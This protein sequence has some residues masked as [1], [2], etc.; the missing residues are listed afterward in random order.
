VIYSGASK[1]PS[2]EEGDML[3]VEKAINPDEMM[4]TLQSNNRNI[5][6]ITND[7]KAISKGILEGKG[8]VGKL[9]SDETLLDDF[10][11]T[12]V[13]L[14]KASSNAQNLSSSIAVY[15]SNLQRKGT[16]ANDLVTDTTI[17]SRLRQTAAQMQEVSSKANTVVENL[18]TTTNG[19]NTKLNNNNTPVGVLLNDEDAAADMRVTLHNLQTSSIK[20]DENLE[21]L[22]HNFLLRG[23]FKKKAKKEAEEAK[24]K[25][26][27]QVAN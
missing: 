7:F 26:K 4:I 16:L 22:Q 14:R 17:F 19:L 12:M 25:E 27:P 15:A 1:S 21:A 9:L 23:F 20:L 2:V 10:E 11:R 8:T 13:M 18:N 24:L 6:E 5:L 3:G